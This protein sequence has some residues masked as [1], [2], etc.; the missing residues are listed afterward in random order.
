VNL[1]VSGA[2]TIAGPITLY[3]ADLT[4]N[5]ALTATNSNINLHASG[6]VSQTAALTAN[7][8]GLHGTGTF[9]L[10]NTSNNIVTIAGGDNTTKL[11]S[12]SYVDASG[13]L[14]IGSVNPD[15]IYSSGPIL[16]ETLG[17]DITLSQNLTTDDASADAIILNA[18]KSSAIGTATGGDIKVSGTPTITMGSGGIAK[19]FSGSDGS[20][21]GL[22]TLV[23]NSNV[24]TGFD[25]GSDLSGEGL[26]GDNTYAIYRVN[27]GNG[28][29]T[30]VASGGDAENSTW[31]FDSGTRILTTI[32]S[33]ANVDA[34]LVE[35]YLASGD[36]TIQAGNITVD[37]NVNSTSAHA[38]TLKAKG[39]ILFNGTS[40]T[41]VSVTTQGGNIVVISNTDGLNGGSI[42]TTFAT[43]R[44]NGGD[45]TFGGG[46]SDGSS[47]AEGS[48]LATDWQRYRGILLNGA[49]I[50]ALGGNIVLRG[51][52]WQGASWASPHP[53]DFAMGLDINASAIS[54]NGNGII[55]IDGVG[56]KNFNA[57][58]HGVGVG[59][60][61]GNTI[62][63]ESG[64][65]SI[66][67]TAGTGDATVHAG[68]YRGGGDPIP[69]IY[70]TSGAITLTGSGSA[71]DT[72]I[73]FSAGFNLGWDGASAISSGDVSLTADAMSF[74]D[75]FTVK[76]TGELVVK[77][78]SN[79]FRAD[80]S[81]PLTNVS[82]GNTLGGL[83][84]GKSTNTANITIASAQT[85]AGPI[86]VYGGNIN[87]LADLL[88]TTADALKLMSSKDIVGATDSEIST[89]GGAILLASDT[90]A[91]DGGA[92][93]ISGV[94]VESNGGNI[95]LGGGDLTG[96]GYAEGSSFGAIGQRY[97]GMWV[98][99]S[100]L[101]AS[102]TST[103]GDI[104]LRG[105][106]W[107]EEGTPFTVNQSGSGDYAIGVDITVGTQI[108][109]GGT[110]TITIDGLGGKNNSSNSH[111]VGINFF[112]GPSIF[113]DAGN[114]ILSGTSGTGLAREYSGILMDGGSPA[115]IY[116]TT[117][118]ISLTGNGS[119]TDTGIKFFAGLNLGWD[120]TNS[121]TTGDITL[122]ADAMSFAD[123]FAVKTTG[124]LAVESVSDSFR[125]DLSWPLTNLSIGNTL[126][127][128]RLGKST[129]TANITIASPQTVS[130]PITLYGGD[131]GINAVLTA[132]DDDI[133]LHS[134]GAVTQTAA[135]TADALALNGAGTFSLTNTGN[136][137]A[138]IAGGSDAAKLGSLSYVDASGGLEI[139][140]VN[141]DGIYST[142]VIEIA[143]LSGDLKV[144][145]PIVSTL[146]T[147]D[148]VK[149]FAD[150][151]AAAGSAGDGNIKISGSG[152]IAVE[153]GA[154]ALL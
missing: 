120:G 29:L 52:G 108:K 14:E 42:L 136:N 45:I 129:N 69:S 86:T 74:V 8:L 31:S 21:T 6:A 131:L 91:T 154:R 107:Q 105:R 97:R 60:F 84:L 66:T 143:T 62:S 58:T 50:D 10:T 37:A 139:G 148:A 92:I 104:V 3:G 80:L 124:E 32:S 141:P 35:G 4:F 116:T 83:R 134:S 43:I 130:G 103:N 110:G 98:D 40:T 1:T 56:G 39:N 16:V 28:D 23:G 132:T 33:P 102:G 135:L 106:G 18:G 118:S 12:L 79:S 57:S 64:S 76:T 7:G 123:G 70:S 63:S 27:A 48:S 75:G 133:N 26:V 77:S 147:G 20:S 72:G 44:T 101:D 109:T 142:G 53:S 17:G 153:A 127:G 68:I 59:L 61:A 126:G 51:R 22:T 93:L 71:T 152:S 38:L 113:T 149:L 112:D 90:D 78:V 138:T 122:T 94:A 128:L 49:T 54:T 30:I 88:V 114:I 46:N 151:D 111:G 55:T 145:Q 25:E 96:S 99:Q 87:L 19:L 34:S 150:Q 81:W 67:G 121:G 2:T 117:G 115:S 41:S 137:V 15:G 146:A 140:S 36:L 125:A 95:T 119:A 82:I 24:R 89:Q 11:G 5:A 144:N 100:T 85:V 65:I 13:G 73:E 47:Y 9:T